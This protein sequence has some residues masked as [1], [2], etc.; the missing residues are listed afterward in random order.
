MR[1]AIEDEM[2]YIFSSV[3]HITDSSIVRAQIQK[4]S[5]GFGTFVATRIAEVQSKSDPNEW[6]WI[7]YG[8][9]PADLLTR[10]QDP[11]NVAVVYSWK[12]GPE[13][14][15]LPLEVW[16]IS[17]SVNCELPDRIHVNLPQYSVHEETII[18]ASK[19]NNYNMLIAVTARIFNI[20]V[21]SFKGVLK[22]HDPR[23]LQEAERF[24]IM[25]AQKSLPE[26]WEKCFQRLGPFQAENGTIMVGQRME[27]WLKHN[28]NQD[29]FILLP[30]KHPFTVLYISYLHRLDHAG[31]D[32]TLC[33]LQSKFWVPSAR[34]IIRSIKRG[35]ILCRKLDAKVEGQRMGQISDERM[36]LCPAF[37]H[38]AV[39]IFGHF[40]IK[41]NVKKRTTGKAYSI[42]LLHVPCILML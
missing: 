32:V 20:K 21:K 15:A 5:Y 4:E 37:Y 1:K 12:Y 23:S 39:D 16:P 19:F 11:L 22:K 3:M 28:W 41:D 30:G 24:W 2:T 29:S 14:M 27:R 9:N 25:Q 42:V 10:P 35:C 31:V 17:Q 26:N 7:A 6:W 8:L 13:F 34:K 18:D 33:K 40:Q 36:S 38:T